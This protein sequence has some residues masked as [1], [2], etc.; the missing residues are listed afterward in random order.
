LRFFYEDKRFDVIA[1]GSLL[2]LKN[3]SF[4]PVGSVT[5][6]QMHSLDFEEFLWAN[7]VGKDMIE[8][9]QKYYLN[10]KLIIPDSINIKMNKLFNMYMLIGGMPKAV[11]TYLETNDINKVKKIKDDI[12]IGY[13]DD[14][15]KHADKK[16]RTKIIDFFKSIPAQLSK[17]NTKFMFNMLENGT[18]YERF[19]DAI[20]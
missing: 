17:E 3:M 5:Y 14:I 13:K 2:G 8:P 18:R 15:E 9:L 11:V 4:T 20:N 6:L 10:P 1:T 16:N 12:I 19:E 7:G